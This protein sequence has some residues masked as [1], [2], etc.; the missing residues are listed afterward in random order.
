MAYPEGLL[1]TRAVIR[2]G[3]YAVIP[4]EGRVRNVIPGIEGCNMSIIASPKLGASFVQYV[5]SA[6]PG[7][8]TVAPFAQDPGVEAFLYVMDGSGALTAATALA[9]AKGVGST[10]VGTIKLS[11]QHETEGDNFE[12][13]VLYGGT[14]QLMRSIYKVMTDNGYPASFAY[15][16]AVRSI[17]SII[18]DI[19]E[20]GV[21]EYLTRRASRTCEFAVRTSGPRVINEDAIQQIFEETEK[22]I[23]ARNWLNEFNLG[24]PTLNRMR[25]TWADSDMER[26]GKLFRDKFDMS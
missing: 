7:G 11:F 2:P 20:V 24:M 16:K 6:L 9:I 14:I 1:K 21:E 19:D 3:E 12:E 5:G 8:G 4:P 17:R 10:R 13:Q 26:T 25:R 22:G 23:F 18:D 15:A